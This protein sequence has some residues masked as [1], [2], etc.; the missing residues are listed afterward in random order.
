MRGDRVLDARGWS[1]AW[2]SLKVMSMLKLLKPGQVLEVLGTD[3]DTLK[4][5]PHILEQSEDQLIGIDKQPEFFRLYLR[6]GRKID[7]AWL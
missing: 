3:P 7:E 4:D 2:C 1:C 6:R 5:L